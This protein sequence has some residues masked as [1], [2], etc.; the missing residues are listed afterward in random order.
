M[1]TDEKTNE[2]KSGFSKVAGSAGAAA[3]VG[4]TS[5]AI[6]MMG[7]DGAEDVVE[8]DTIDTSADEIADI[9]DAAAAEEAAAAQ[10]EAE[11]APE[12][13]A[14]PHHTASHT[15]SAPSPE[16]PAE[17]ETAASAEGADAVVVDDTFGDDVPVVE[18]TEVEVEANEMAEAEDANIH[19]DAQVDLAANE[20]VAIPDD[21]E[22]MA[23][24]I[25]AE[26]SADMEA[27]AAVELAAA[28]PADLGLDMSVDLAAAEPAEMGD[29]D[30]EPID[31]PLDAQ[32]DFSK[33]IPMNDMDLDDV[34]STNAVNDM[35]ASAATDSFGD[36]VIEP[37]QDF[38]NNLINPTEEAEGTFTAQIDQPEIDSSGLIQ[39]DKMYDVTDAN[40][41]VLHAAEFHY[42]DDGFPSIMADTTGDGVY[43]SIIDAAGN[44][45]GA[46]PAN[47][48]VADAMM[49]LNQDSDYMTLD[50]DADF[51]ASVD[52][53]YLDN[54]TDTGADL[55]VDMVDTGIDMG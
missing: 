26:A 40:G 29:L 24:D 34:V 37:I 14:A 17:T 52:P 54:I 25:A 2:K 43:D 28:E 11:S 4:A 35:A 33:A 5:V 48:E 8:V 15:T 42:S 39:Y 38:V 12:A 44:I 9:S 45:L 22:P 41:N 7:D 50:T 49:Q 27:D 51:T 23:D 13:A 31:I 20:P 19:D 30:L 3:V 55:G 6:G 53:S 47:M 16:Q 32:D 1:K 36:M 18:E 21:D 10:Q 46:A